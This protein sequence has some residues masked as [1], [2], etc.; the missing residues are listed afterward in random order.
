MERDL[1]SIIDRAA[2]K[3]GYETIKDGQRETVKKFV[4]GNDVF[5]ALPTG[6]GKSFC[7]AVL[8]FLLSST[9]GWDALLQLQSLFVCLPYCL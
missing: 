6:F 1:D 5:V 9:I 7:Y 8:R 2:A 3:L 4:K